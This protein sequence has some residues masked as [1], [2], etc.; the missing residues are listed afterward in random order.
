MAHPTCT[1]LPTPLSLRSIIGGPNIL[2]PILTPRRGNVFY[3]TAFDSSKTGKPIGTGYALSPISKGEL[4]ADCAGKDTTRFTDK[5]MFDFS[6]GQA[7]VSV[8]RFG[9]G[10]GRGGGYLSVR[11]VE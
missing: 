2:D 8:E 7:G 4:Y 1:D 10:D 3:S 6:P 11:R 9:S 5:L